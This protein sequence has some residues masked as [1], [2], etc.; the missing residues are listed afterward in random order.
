MLINI[1]FKITATTWNCAGQRWPLCC[2]LAET[3][4]LSRPS[5]ILWLAVASTPR[6]GRRKAP[7]MYR[8]TFPTYLAFQTGLTSSRSLLRKSYLVSWAS[9]MC[10]G[11]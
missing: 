2:V 1:Y 9:S 7:T 11:I 5:T 8:C 6:P 4:L 10:S 3:A